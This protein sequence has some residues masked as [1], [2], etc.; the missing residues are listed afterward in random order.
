[1]TI[2][3]T[4][5]IPA[6]LLLGLV[7]LASPAA[8]AS[9]A[10]VEATPN[11][12]TLNWTAPG[13][14][15]NSGTA[16][17]YDIR[18]STSTITDANWGSATQATGEP[19]P[20]A[21]GTAES[22]EVTGLAPS[23]TYYFAIKAADEVP[24]WS[25][26]SNIAVQTTSDENTPPV[27]V[28]NLAVQSAA[29]TS[30][31]IT[32]TAPGDDGSVG[33]A[34]T[35]DIRYATTAI[36]AANWS[37][38]TQ[39]SGEPSPQTAGATE[40]FE[41]TGLDPNTTYYFCLI[42]ADE[43]PNWSNLSNVASGAT[44][45]ETTPPDDI[46]NLLAGSPTETTVLLRWTAPGDDGSSG[47]ASQYD[48]RY[49][50]ATITAA[51]FS[52]ATAVLAPP[53]PQSAGNTQTFVVS[54]LTSETTY[55]F[56]IKT[57]DEVPNWSNISNVVSATTANDATAPDDVTTLAAVLPTTTSLTL[58]WAAPGD[59]GSVGTAASYDI[60]YST[61]TITEANWSAA[62]QLS[63]EPTPSAAGEVD[64]AVVSGLTEGTT[65]Y[66]ALKASDERGN[67]S[68]L[69]NVASNETSPDTTPPSA[70]NDL[71][72]A[73]GTEEGEIDLSWTAP[74]DDGVEGQA[75]AYEIRFSPNMIDESNWETA[76]ACPTPPSP[77]YCGTGQGHTLAALV[78]GDTYYIGIKAY[79]DAG[80]AS[81]IS[82]VASAEAKFE[83]IL[84][85]GNLAQP[86]SPP[87]M[88]VLPTAR[89]VLVVNNADPS[90]QNVYRFELA[91]DSNFFELVAGG[92][93]LQDLG[94]TTSWQVDN[95]LQPEQEYFWRVATNE[96]GYSDVFSFSV[97]PSAH[98]Y[99][100]PV[101]FS[102]TDAAIFTDLPNEG[103]L[104]V[105]SLSGSV[106]KR[107]ADLDGQDVTWDG[108]NDSG[109]RVASGT[110]LWFLPSSGAKGKLVVIN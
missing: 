44:S 36:T 7:L 61:S 72:A 39:V 47:T 9:L 35:Y 21:A 69:S 78:P 58:V 66:F 15:D 54:G 107:W 97:E 53:T 71:T 93:V 110:Y 55:F 29:S 88:A 63:S 34:S 25:P 89:P 102:Q 6:I 59:D 45:D 41:I 75:F 52:S 109:K 77:E 56:A 24:N 12:I 87:P 5:R 91:T 46:T 95:P 16:S 103:D 70:I 68:G 62:T 22:F 31:T 99:P 1:M 76:S 85:N 43:V 40:S 101:Y 20:S 67:E 48:I 51:N 2:S 80:N 32:W 105:T 64:S 106:V 27:A 26:L 37:S 108:T 23:T 18:Y 49:S 11:S 74:G 50:T 100:N 82:N 8:E 42:T 104:M 84:A 98:A 28:A 60:R 4:H 57:A 83:F 65:Y 90:P 10:T 33:T 73:P 19:S 79:D 14:D 96:D 81:S 13:D 38:A 92:V 3:T 30:I 94:T 86:S 17:Q